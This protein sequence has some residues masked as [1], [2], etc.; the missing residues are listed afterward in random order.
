MRTRVNGWLLRL[1]VWCLTGQDSR[2]VQAA[3]LRVTQLPDGWH[4]WGSITA[5]SGEIYVVDL[6]AEQAA[7]V[8]YALVKLV[9]TIT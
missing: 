6:S 3:T 9:E 8:G 5:L 1:M 7:S 2:L 4:V